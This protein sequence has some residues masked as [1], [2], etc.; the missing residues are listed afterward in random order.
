MDVAT[1]R[2]K[3]LFKPCNVVI[4]TGHLD[5]LTS[6]KWTIDIPSIVMCAAIWHH[7]W[8]LDSTEYTCCWARKAV[9][10]PL[11]KQLVN[12]LLGM[13]WCILLWGY[14][15]LCTCVLLSVQRVSSKRLAH[16]F[17]DS[18]MQLLPCAHHKLVKLMTAAMLKTSFACKWK[19]PRKC[20]DCTM[21][22]SE[23]TFQ[24]HIKSNTHCS[25]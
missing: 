1:K 19:Q 10:L 25:R 2:L 14:L 17:L 23:V 4:Y 21:K 12:A 15:Y 18:F 6:L 16:M 3:E 20:K 7:Q 5:I 9:L 13:W 11:S 24:K 22:R 8:S